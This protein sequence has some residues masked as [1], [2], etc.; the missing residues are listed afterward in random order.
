MNIVLQL[1]YDPQCTQTIDGAFIRGNAPALWLHEI[2]SW[3]IPLTGMT[4]LIIPEHTGSVTP[5]GLFVV[6]G[7]NIPAADHIT[8]A[9]SA[10]GKKLFIPLHASLYP[11]L[12]DDEMTSLLIWEW[13][14]FHPGIG[15][16]GFNKED[17]LELSAL[18]SFP[19]PVIT[20]W[21][22][23]HPGI[24][25]MAK[26]M[27]ISV[28]KPAQEEIPDQQEK[29]IDVLP[30]SAITGRKMPFRLSPVPD[31]IA[32]VLMMPIWFMLK[33]CSLVLEVMHDVNILKSVPQSRCRRFMDWMEGK[34]R[35]I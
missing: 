17:Q 34:S 33:L 2:D 9:Y 13:Q 32:R 18:V 3:Q 10:I 15:F 27:E 4:Y 21:D 28:D 14:V 31:F 30:Q 24:P 8:H 12:S 35:L 23:A 20:R 7:K 16:T 1:T 22:L 11:L 5:A 6:F 26:L 25:P 29:G 19:E